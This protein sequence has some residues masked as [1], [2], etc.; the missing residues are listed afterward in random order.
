MRVAVLGAGAVALGNAALLCA[1]GHEPILWSPSGRLT[2][3]AP[4]V[5]Q[6][7]VEGR[8]HP[9]VA[10]SCAAALTDAE[11]VLIAVPGYAHRAVIDAAAPHLRAGQAVL[12]SS[13]MSFSALYLQ[14][15]TGAR[16]PIVA[17]G[18]TI[19]TGRRED[20]A[21]VRVSHVRA[22][23][24]TAVLAPADTEA[25]LSVCRALFGDRFVSR[26]GLLAIALSNLN[27][28]NHMAI[29]LC[30]LTRMEKAERWG[31]YTH[32]TESVGRLIEALDTERLAIAAALG[33]QV[34]SV[35]EHFR[36]S[37]GAEGDTLAEMARSLVARG[38]DVDGPATPDSRYVTEDV[39][40]G[41]WPTVRL[42][43]TIGVPA[44]L[45]ESGVRVFSALYGRDFAAEN[46]ILPELEPLAGMVEGM[47]E[48]DFR[49]TSPAP[50]V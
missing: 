44:P 2:P 31:Q 6:G 4:L 13:H 40:F 25:A 28:Q 19:T 5:A 47:R 9:G 21:A 50:Q 36:L 11:A 12:F 22:R 15:R 39:P 49:P 18:T 35:H 33:V 30:N 24:D 17:W 41:L 48:T 37:F 7:A 38:A 46:D 27:P 23:I 42:A 8:F 10:P 29:A 1:N 20:D 32:M 45:H 43:Q 16:V 14:R 26:D 3:G 34:R